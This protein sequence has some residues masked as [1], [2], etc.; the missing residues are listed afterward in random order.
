[1]TRI[2]LIGAGVIANTHLQASQQLSNVEITWVADIDRVRAETLASIVGAKATDDPAEAIAAADTDAVIVAVP[3]LSHRPMV[4]LAA[5]HGKAVLCEKPL[6][7]TVADAEAI[8]ATCQQANVPLTVGQ[9]VRFFPAY[10]RLKAA[11]DEDA[12]GKPGMAR[13]AR[14]GPHPGPTRAWFNDPAA[15]GGVVLDMMIHELDLLRWWFGDVV[16]LYG[17]GMQK[18]VPG[19]DYAQA[20]LRFASG[21]VAHVEA[22]WSHAAFRTTVEIAGERGMVQYDS[23]QAAAIRIDRPEIDGQPSS[24]TRRYADTLGPWREQLRHFVDRLGDGEPFL[25]T[26]E[27][28]VRAVDLALAVRHS[29]VSGQ[30]VSIVN[31]RAVEVGETV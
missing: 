15:S 5:A 6:A 26:G 31:G 22:S 21:T 8:V 28:G 9:V 7:R 2:A 27:D 11:L 12:I 14:I 1:M 17:L 18:V 29:I 30:P 23:E 16:R 3:T 20:S 19:R 25:V 24:V 10:Q 4:E 13:V